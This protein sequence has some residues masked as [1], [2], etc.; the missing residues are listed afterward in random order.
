VLHDPDRMP[1]VELGLVLIRVDRQDAEA[2]EPA[3]GQELVADLPVRNGRV[4]HRRVGD[5]AAGELEDESE[6]GHARDRRRSQ[7]LF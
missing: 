3:A 5:V 2:L 6:P 1:D 4:E 7:R